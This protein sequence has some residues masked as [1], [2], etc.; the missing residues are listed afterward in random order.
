MPDFANSK[1]YK[2]YSNNLSDTCYIGS[3]VL[4]LKRRLSIHVCDAKNKHHASRKI[5]EAGNYHMDELEAYPCTSLMELRKREQY[6]MEKLV[7]CNKYRA[8][9]TQEDKKE[10]R[11]VH[12]AK[13]R[14]KRSKVPV[15]CFCGGTYIINGKARHCKTDKHKSAVDIISMV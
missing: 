5:I 8:F 1:I 15:Q 14:A 4:T 9:Q 10:Q 7:C 13:L 12:N 3:T 11:R 6:W 2:L